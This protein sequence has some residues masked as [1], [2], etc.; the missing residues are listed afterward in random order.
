MLKFKLVN[1]F[2]ILI[3]NSVSS[4]GQLIN[5]VPDT[6]DFDLIAS[7]S[8]NNQ[9][10]QV[11]DLT[12]DAYLNECLEAHNEKRRLHGSEDLVYDEKVCLK[13]SLITLTASETG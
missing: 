8:A 3:I 4:N 9:Y 2:I 1:L 10:S 13:S 7:E 12:N 5:F 11:L 6:N